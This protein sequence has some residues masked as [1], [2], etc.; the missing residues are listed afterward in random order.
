MHRRIRFSENRISAMM[1]L[2]Q[3]TC[4]DASKWKNGDIDVTDAV[5]VEKC[6]KCTWKSAWKFHLQLTVKSSPCWKLT[7]QPSL[8]CPRS[9]VKRCVWNCSILL[10]LVF[11]FVIFGLIAFLNNY[12]VRFFFLSANSY[13]RRIGNWMHRG[14]EII[15]SSRN[16]VLD[17]EVDLEKQK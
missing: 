10:C 4:D 17:L 13:Q 8:P 6:S 12:D 5:C 2:L 11:P 3:I 14:K 1:R 7:A 9:A 15:V 16:R